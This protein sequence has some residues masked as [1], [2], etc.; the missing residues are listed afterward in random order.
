M[1]I[2]NTLLKTPLYNFLFSFSFYGKCL[3][4]HVQ[5]QQRKYK[6]KY[7][8]IEKLHLYIVI[9]IDV[10][11]LIESPLKLSPN[12]KCYPHSKE[13]AIYLLKLAHKSQNHY[14]VLFFFWEALQFEATVP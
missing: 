7:V 14:F 4:I 6:R 13:G 3:A 2:R 12:E 9:D 8:Y 11:V 10:G 1:C 5:F